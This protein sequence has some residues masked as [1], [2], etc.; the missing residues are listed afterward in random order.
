[1][2]ENIILHKQSYND[3]CIM[4][5]ILVTTSSFTKIKRLNAYRIY[6][7]ILFLSEILDIK[8]TEIITGSMLG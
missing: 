2:K 4:E 6:L 3:S 1:M 8:G 7:R 5:D